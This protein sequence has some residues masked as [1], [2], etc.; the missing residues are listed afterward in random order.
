[1][2]K[3]SVPYGYQYENGK[4]V[5]NSVEQSIVL[6]ICSEYIQGQSLLTIANHLNDDGI[7]YMSG[8]TG[9]NKGKIKRMI[10]D[11]RYLGNDIFSPLIDEQVFKKMQGVKKGKDT[12]RGTDKDRDIYKIRVPV[13]CPICGSVMQRA[14]DK[15]CRSAQKWVCQNDDCRKRVVISDDELVTAL[16]KKINEVISDPQKIIF[17]EDDLCRPNQET[18]RVENEINRA[19]EGYSFD[20]A[21]LREK[22]LRRVS[23]RYEEI[24]QEKYITKQL[25]AEFAN[26][27]PLSSFSPELFNRAA[28]E[29]TIN[30]DEKVSIRLING[31][32]I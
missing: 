30:D 13:K 26:A 23:L 16:V 31:Q 19:L 12:R 5:V 24:P 15:R 22:M 3:R 20:K 21:A 17:T 29:I 27:I 8:V 14:Y 7:E 25:R 4:I 28:E 1:M 10:E 6:R 11:E 18:V 32:I 2:K 9:W